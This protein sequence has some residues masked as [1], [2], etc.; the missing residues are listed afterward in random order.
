M[1]RKLALFRSLPS[2]ARVFRGGRMTDFGRLPRYA[3]IFT[4]GSASV[5]TPITAYVTMTPPS[6]TSGVSLILP[7]SGAQASVNL[8][9]IGQASS[10]A[11]SAFSSSRISPT[12]TYKR[13]LAAHRTLDR[14]ADAVGLDLAQFG[15]P[16]IKLVDETSLIHFE[17]TGGSPEDAQAR[18]D[19]VLDVFLDELDTL[20]SDEIEHR[21]QAASAAIA[22][23]EHA[24]TD[25]RVEIAAVQE[26]SGL[27]SRDHYEA[28]VAERDALALRLEDAMSERDAAEAAKCAL[29]ARLGVDPETAALNLRLHADPE[30]Q[31]LANALALQSSDLAE[32]RGRY[33]ARHPKVTH[34]MQAVAGAKAQLATRGRAVIGEG[35]AVHMARLDMSPDPARAALLSDLVAHA[36]EA[37]ARAA[38]VAAQTHQL[39]LLDARVARLAPLAA[40]L[41]ELTRD[42]KVAEAVLA[43]ALARTDTSRADIFAS[44]PLVQVLADASLPDQAT[45]PQPKIAV[46]AGIAATIMLLMTLTLAWVRRSLIDRLLHRADS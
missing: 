36:T 14:A 35:A 44:Y 32:N 10:S 7:G 38:T 42:Y 2:P 45:S 26:E 23:Y 33:G 1:F 30:F 12:Q 37:E 27:I 3:L 8:T 25:L 5:W 13:L 43:S 34:A 15:A 46:A 39:R 16:R 11:A 22:G 29:S 17:M 19:A 24:V 4:L 6:F 21:E 18:A 20:R 28:L 9:D 31:E 40:R 41:D